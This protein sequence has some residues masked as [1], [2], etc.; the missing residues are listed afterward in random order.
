LRA[1]KSGSNVS[2]LK[3]RSIDKVAHKVL[4]VGE[5]MIEL[6]KAAPDDLWRIGSGGD[7]LNMA[8]HLARLGCE[9]AFAS[10][11]GADPFA[12]DLRE[13]CGREGLDLGTLLTDPQRTTGLY[14]I[15]TDE[16]GERS[17]TYWRRESAARHLFAH[18]NIERVEAAAEN[19]DLVVF[20]LISLAILPAEGRQRL[21]D[22]VMRAA[23]CGAKVAF[24]G[25]YRAT[26]WDDV[27]AARR[28]RDPAIAL[29]D[30]GLP[31]L[32]D[33]HAIDGSADAEKVAARWKRAGANEVVVKLGA[34]GCFT[35]DG[36]VAPLIPLEPLDTT[37]AGDAFNAGYL[38]ARL[39]QQDVIAAA[40]AGHELAAWTLM[41]QGSIPPVTPDAPY[42]QL[43][44]VL[45]R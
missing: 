4:V 42:A 40:K 9:V 43:K 2:A 18:P 10:V 6:S 22:L 3:A 16:A 19:A 25:N 34:E 38:Y 23:Q 30:F 31:T 20:S 7:T 29:C 8:V 45:G 27:E 11:V 28:A 12:V 39:Q 1:G 37:G 44:A 33:E 13:K 35:A 15:H 24:D 17:F 41:Q 32:D 14:A 26:L 21:R 36:V 5:G